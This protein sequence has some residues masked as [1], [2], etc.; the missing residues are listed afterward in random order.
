MSGMRQLEI[1]TRRLVNDSLAGEYH[2]VFKGRGMDFDE[3]R[4][5]SPGDE[6]R[7]IDWNVTARAGRPFVKK[8]TEERELTILLLVDISASGNFGSADLSKRDLAAELASVL[9]FS[10]IRNSDKVGLLLYTDR[11]ERYLPPKK[12]RRHVLRVVRDIL[13]HTPEGRGTDSVKALDVANHVLHRRAIVFLISDFQSPG[14]G[15]YPRGIAPRHAPDQSTSRS[16]RRASRGPAREGTS[17]RRS[18]RAGRRGDRRDHRTRHRQ[19]RRAQALQGV[20]DRTRTAIGGRFARRGRRH[21]GTQDR[22]ALHARPAAILQD[23][24]APT[25]MSRRMNP[26]VS[27]ACTAVA[28]ALIA[29]FAMALPVTPAAAA[30]AAANTTMTIN[31][32]ADTSANTH[33][34][35]TSANVDA[36]A[37]GS[38]ANAN[39]YV[40][41][42][43]T[44]SANANTDADANTA[45]ADDIRDIRGPKDIFPLWL[46]AAW[47]AGAALLAIGGYAAWRWARRRSPKAQQRFEIALQQLE[48][49][50]ALMQPSS[51]REFSIAIS[52]IVR[53]YIEDEFKVTATHRTTE[54]FLRDLLESSNAS[55]AAHRNLLA[56]F[57]NQC[58]VAKFAGVGLSMRIMET[59][60]QSARTFVIESSKPLPAAEEHQALGSA[61]TPEAH[62]SLPST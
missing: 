13:Y 39:T 32:N 38:N 46:L 6:V 33:A 52:D 57:L 34:T 29:P 2:S 14:S 9:A 50:R 12:G 3:V 51:V 26:R 59:L 23:A 40:A 1:R 25:R 7:T 60:H 58:D 18:S 31:A 55:L 28:L 41:N 48:G 15:P 37:T 53:R 16:H 62:D 47:L 22:F 21:L 17:Q 8:F 11:V 35:T 27:H 56:Q 20:G 43:N 4:E 49:I 10:A 19:R 61:R 24:R 54:E 45:A 5:Y 36:N 30:A 44:S 42:S